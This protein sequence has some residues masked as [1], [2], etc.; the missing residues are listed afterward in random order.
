MLETLT[1]ARNKSMLSR[2]AED[3]LVMC[4]DAGVN[5]S[6]MIFYVGKKTENGL[7]LD[8]VFSIGHLNNDS[9]VIP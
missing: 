9:G 1:F 7:K 4:T 5:A 8:F 3:L 2:S 6:I